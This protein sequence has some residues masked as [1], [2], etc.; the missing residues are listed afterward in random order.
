MERI[1][2]ELVYTWYAQYSYPS[3]ESFSKVGIGFLIAE[4]W[5]VRRHRNA[6]NKYRYATIGKG[7]PQVGISVIA[8]IHMKHR[9]VFS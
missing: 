3:I 7:I 6:T 8:S 4:M 5:Q 1:S 2:S 9:V